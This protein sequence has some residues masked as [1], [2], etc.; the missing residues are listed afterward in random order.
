MKHTVETK[1]NIRSLE[2]F[3]FLYILFICCNSAILACDCPEI[4]RY[5]LP[6]Y[7]DFGGKRSRL[8]EERSLAI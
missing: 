5:P 6:L 8:E 4:Q 3:P 2:N 1:E 7:V